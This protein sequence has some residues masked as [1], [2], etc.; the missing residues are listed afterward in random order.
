MGLNEYETL[1]MTPVTILVRRE[2]VT[3]TSYTRSTML[4]EFGRA[5]ADATA[6]ERFSHCRRFQTLLSQP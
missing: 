6:Q 4:G 3:A 1:E 5:C 2:L